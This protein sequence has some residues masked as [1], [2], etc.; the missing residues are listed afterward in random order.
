MSMSGHQ[1]VPI[2]QKTYLTCAI[3]LPRVASGERRGV[4]GKEWTVLAI[5]G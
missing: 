5:E 4:Q 2:A 3:N 1:L